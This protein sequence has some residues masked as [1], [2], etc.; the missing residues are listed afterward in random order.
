MPTRSE[1]DAAIDQVHYRLIDTL[2]DWIVR[3]KRNLDGFIDHPEGHADYNK[4]L[5]VD[6]DALK[7]RSSQLDLIAQALYTISSYKKGNTNYTRAMHDYSLDNVPAVIWQRLYDWVNKRAEEMEQF[8]ENAQNN[9]P[10]PINDYRG[11]VTFDADKYKAELA[12]YQSGR[13]GLAVVIAFLG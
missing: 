11:L 6:F 4:Y 9:P 10:V 7:N 8:L 13:D 12:M 2:Y 5:I 3:E 1:R